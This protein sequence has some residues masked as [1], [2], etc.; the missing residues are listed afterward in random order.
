[1]IMVW[2]DLLKKV[3]SYLS[4]TQ[5][6]KKKSFIFFWSFL[7]IEEWRYDAWFEKGNLSI[8]FSFNKKIMIK[9]FLLIYSLV[10]R[11]LKAF[12]GQKKG[13]AELGVR[14]YICTS[15]NGLGS[16]WETIITYV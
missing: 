15:C 6:K 12:L 13:D 2:E 14:K 1:M 11:L 9:D 4:K 16:V 10:G 3:I 5:K 7:T 8:F